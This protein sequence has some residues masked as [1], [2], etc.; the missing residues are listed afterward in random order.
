ML[1]KSKKRFN[2]YVS[3][4]YSGLCIYVIHRFKKNVQNDDN[5]I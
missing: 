1:F 3:Y 4:L 5:V 2:K